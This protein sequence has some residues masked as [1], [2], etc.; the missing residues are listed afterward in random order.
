VFFS[1][2]F[3]NK[4]ITCL[5][6]KNESNPPLGI[7]CN[8]NF[9]IKKAYKFENIF[10]VIGSS[11][12]DLVANTT[13]Y[14]SSYFF[15]ISNIISDGSCKSAAFLTAQ[16][17]VH[18]DNPANIAECSPKFLD[19]FIVFIFESILANSFITEY[20]SSFD[21][22]STNINSYSLS[23]FD[24]TFSFKSAYSGNKLS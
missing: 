9:L 8:A 4:S 15:I 5:S 14:P 12:S 3:T 7:L 16:S 19:N 21:P 24:S 23:N 13:L 10:C 17:P 11:L 20:E 2:I 1:C 22:S 18:C 6:I